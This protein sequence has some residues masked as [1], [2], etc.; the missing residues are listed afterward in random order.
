MQQLDYETLAAR[1]SSRERRLSLITYIFKVQGA[2]LA[3]LNFEDAAEALGVDRRTL[4]RYIDELGALGVL[5]F[6]DHKLKI[7]PE[8]IK[9]EG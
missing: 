3:R 2:E 6:H 1:L 8:Y 9:Q 5:S 7:N 4:G